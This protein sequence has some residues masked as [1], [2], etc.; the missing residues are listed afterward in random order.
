LAET[1]P[2]DLDALLDKD[3]VSLFPDRFFEWLFV[4]LGVN[5]DDEDALRAF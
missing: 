1:T 2:V 5:V 3:D 4:Y